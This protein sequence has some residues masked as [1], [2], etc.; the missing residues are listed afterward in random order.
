M[1]AVEDEPDGPRAPS[2]SRSSMRV[3]DVDVGGR[4]V[5][6]ALARLVDD[7]RA[8][9]RALPEARKSGRR[10]ESGRRRPTRRRPSAPWRRPR[11]RGA[12]R[13]AGVGPRRRGPLAVRPAAAGRELGVAR[14]AARG[15]HDAPRG[16][17]VTGSPAALDDDAGDARRP[18]RRARGAGCRARLGAVPL[19]IAISWATRLGPRESGT[20]RSRPPR[21]RPCEQP[22][23]MRAEPAG[24]RRAS[25]SGSKS[26]ICVTYGGARGGRRS[27]GEQRAEPPAVE[28]GGLE[29][30]PIA[31]GPVRVVV[32]VPRR[33][34][35]G[36][37]APARSGDAAPARVRRKAS[38]PLRRARRGRRRRRSRPGSGAPPRASRRRRPRG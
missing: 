37:R 19:A 32:G 16:P 25:V 7:D 8:R 10:P 17:D 5:D 23:A 20:R 2:R 33:G 36:S 18:R 3:P 38:R 6:E 21:G 11:R 22:R 1:A 35:S 30:R 31:A 26:S 28:D 15:E 34:S 4:L 12:D 27:V 9:Q 29:L 14:E 13:V 24:V